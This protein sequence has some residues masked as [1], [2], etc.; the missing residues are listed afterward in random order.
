MNEKFV[1]GLAIGVAVAAGAL[2]FGPAVARSAQPLV[3]RAMK[4]AVQAYARGRE[5]A[6]ELM[7]MAEDAYAEAW[8]ELKQEAD[9]KVRTAEAAPSSPHDLAS[10]APFEPKRKAR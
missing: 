9:E 1:R 4:S 6:A 2:V 5:A 3:R 7:E 10:E 8:A